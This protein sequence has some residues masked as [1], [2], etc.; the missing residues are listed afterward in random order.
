[1]NGEQLYYTLSQMSMGD[2]RVFL[3]TLTDA[4]KL[5]Y[6]RYSGKMRQQKF[7]EK[8]ENKEALN[9][10]RREYIAK[11]RKEKP[12]EFKQKNI[13]DV[14][15]FREREKSK[16]NEIQSKI[17]ATNILTN[18]IKARKARTEINKLKTESNNKDVKDILNSIIDT[19]PKQADLKKKREY[20]RVYRAEQKAKAKK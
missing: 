19:I 6:K 10:H 13:K 15:A 12:E 7:N 8:P 2:K 17:K 18:A 9:T 5:A 3:A 14:K 11:Q 20:M 4:Q 16:L 1:M